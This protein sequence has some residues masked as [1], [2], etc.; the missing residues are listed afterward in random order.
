MPLY[1]PACRGTCFCTSPAIH[2]PRHA[3]H[4]IT[5]SARSQPRHAGHLLQTLH[6]PSPGMQGICS[7]WCLFT[8]C[9]QQR[10]ADGN[11]QLQ[12]N[13]RLSFPPLFFSQYFVRR[14]YNCFSFLN[15]M[16]VLN[17]I[18][19]EMWTIEILITIF[20]KHILAFVMNTQII[21]FNIT[22]NRKT[23]KQN[24]LHRMCAETDRIEPGHC[25]LCVDEI[26]TAFHSRLGMSP[27]L[28]R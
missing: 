4:I 25:W 3:G 22:F 2:L 27:L 14:T 6:N 24:W 11:A 12:I 15:E 7:D 13:V 18:F 23:Q 21:L 16:F 19:E 26:W 10:A 9:L 1:C 5:S 28:S 17:Y 20:I 8:P